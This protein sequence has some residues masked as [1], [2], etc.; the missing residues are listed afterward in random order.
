LQDRGYLTEARLRR[1]VVRRVMKAGLQYGGFRDSLGQ[2]HL[3]GEAR[4]STSLWALAEDE[5]KLVR[6]QPD[7]AAQKGKAKLAG[8]SPIL[9]VPLDRAAVLADV[10]RNVTDQPAGQ[11]KWPAIPWL[12]IP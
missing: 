7:D 11:I 10:G 4:G 1:E 2:A 6:Y 3:L 5:T 12:E 8:F 9:F